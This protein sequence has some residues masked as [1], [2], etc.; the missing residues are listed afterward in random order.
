MAPTPTLEPFTPSPKSIAHQMDV[1]NEVWDTV[2]EHYLYPDFN[3]LDWNQVK[4][5]MQAKI[6]S[7]LRDSDFYLEMYKM[8]ASLGDN[9]STFFDPEAA[10]AED[11][12]FQGEYNYGGI[13]VLTTVVT[14]TKSL[15]VLIV[16]P[17]S[18]AEAAGIQMHDRILS[19]DGQPLI[20]DQGVRIFNLRGPAGSQVTLEVQTPGQAARSLTITREQINSSMPVPH[21]VLTTPGGKRIGY[22]FIPTFNDRTIAE[23]IGAAIED[24]AQGGDLDGYIL[25]NRYNSGGASTVT[26]NTLAYFTDG[27]V[28][29]FVERNER[30]PLDVQGQDIGGSQTAPVVA[31]V[32]RGTASFGEIFSGILKDLGRATLMG[33]T[34]DGNVE[35]LSIFNFS[36]GS[37]AWIATSTFKPLNDENANW[38]DTGIVPDVSVDSQWDDVTLTTD[39]VITTA[40]ASFDQ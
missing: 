20:D 36:D 25:D 40:L 1:F 26:L 5:D 28:G 18:P 32:G 35:I 12:Q 6:E 15:S 38:E 22:I 19:A 34:T 37:R 13:G 31:L 39:P 23:S 4:K 7:G 9:H 27:Q 11:E 24:M 33:V 8:I 14:Q 30:A 10:K 29:W 16:F 2:N 17:N 3:G 21:Q